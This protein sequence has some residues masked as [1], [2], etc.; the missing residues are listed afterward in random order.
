MLRV[1]LDSDVINSIKDGRNTVL[2]QY[3][4]SNSKKILTPISPAHISDK[5]PSKGHEKFA[6]DLNYLDTFSGN[7][8][9]HF[10]GK[11]K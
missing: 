1:Y 9:I 5:L 11:K 2:S 7:H 3:L 8:V 10:D 4:G 6:T